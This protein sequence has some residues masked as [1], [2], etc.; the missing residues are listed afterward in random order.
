[1]SLRTQS[2]A[3][4]DADGNI[5]CT[6]CDRSLPG[7]VK[8]YHRH[9]DAFKPKCKECRGMSFGVGSPNKVMDTPAGEKICTGCE[10]VLPADV[11]HFYRTDKTSDGRTSKCKECRSGTE[12]GTHRPNRVNN[13]PEGMWFCSSC[14]QTLPL[15]GRFFYE[16]EGGFEVYCKACSTQRK[17]QMRRGVDELSGREWRFIKALWLDAGVV[18]CA[19]CGDEAP[20]PERDHVQ[21]LSDGGETAPEN[22]VPACR[23][24]NRKKGHRPVTAWYPDADV[25]DPGRWERIQSHLR[26]ETQIPS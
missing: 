3:R 15:N 5:V 7:T 10:R 25:F 12:F 8:Y 17:N 19:Y 9:R 13:I 20:A 11:D 14:E 18:T 4:P 21:P 26:G 24:C 22:I 23:S 16:V 6:G 2:M 1:M